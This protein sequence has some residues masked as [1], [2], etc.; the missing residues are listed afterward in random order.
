M[1][2]PS[3]LQD[4]D[5]G[6]IHSY[7]PIILRRRDPIPIQ[8]TTNLMVQTEMKE[9]PH[10][11]EAAVPERGLCILTDREPEEIESAE[12]EVEVLTAEQIEA[13]KQLRA[14]EGKLL[15]Y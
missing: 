9:E 3:H 12:E 7:S 4:F 11:K 15:Q 8:T 13:A 10:A 5:S 14:I 2:K 6:S 1:L